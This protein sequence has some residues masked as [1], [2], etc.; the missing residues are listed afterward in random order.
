ML[1][2]ALLSSRRPGVS[3][4]AFASSSSRVAVDRANRIQSPSPSHVE[5][6]AGAGAGGGVG[7][8]VG[9]V[10]RLGAELEEHGAE[11]S[12]VGTWHTSY[13]IRCAVGDLGVQN[14]M[15]AGWR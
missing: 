15:R 13:L 2:S 4:R 9:D 12:L 14:T 8:G 7:V 10:N 5:T 3:T 6:G 1:S 11:L